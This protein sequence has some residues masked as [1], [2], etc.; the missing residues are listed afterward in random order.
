VLFNTKTRQQQVGSRLS[1]KVGDSVRVQEHISDPTHAWGNVSPGDVGVVTSISESHMHVDF[2]TQ[3][4]WSAVAD[5]MEL[6]EEQVK[7]P[8]KSPEK[9]L[10]YAVLDAVGTVYSFTQD[11]EVARQTKANLGGKQN[12]VTI[13]VLKQGKEVR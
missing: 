1:F 11:R 2:P 7:S 4:N 6:V 9:I 12:G 8:R 13:V 5:E 10:G 3:G